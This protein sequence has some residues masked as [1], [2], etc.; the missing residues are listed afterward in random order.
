MVL[1]LVS[2]S[3]CDINNGIGLTKILSIPI[4]T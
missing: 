1:T 2:E 3:I 4:P